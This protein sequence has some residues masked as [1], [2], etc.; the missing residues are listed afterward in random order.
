MQKKNEQ[1]CDKGCDKCQG[2][3]KGMRKDAHQSCAIQ[4]KQQAIYLIFKTAVFTTKYMKKPDILIRSWL[5][6]DDYKKI[7]IT[8]G[9][10]G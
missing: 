7:T 3:I 4:I 2:V 8:H 9:H 6:V 10:D 1:G 5:Y